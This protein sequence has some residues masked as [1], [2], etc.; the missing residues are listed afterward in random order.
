MFTIS[1]SCL[2]G[3]FVGIMLT[4]SGLGQGLS[5]LANV[6]EALIMFA[7]IMTYCVL[8]MLCGFFSIFFTKEKSKTEEK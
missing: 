5:P 4:F 2:I 3:V 7:I 6:N 8:G 1:I